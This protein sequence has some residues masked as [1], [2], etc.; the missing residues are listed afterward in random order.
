M[1]KKS[2]GSRLQLV[3]AAILLVLISA[4]APKQVRVYE[5]GQGARSDIIQQ[6]ISMLG[7]PYKNGAKGP[8]AFDCSGFIHYVY[9]QSN[10]ILPVMTEKQI[11]AGLDVSPTNVLPGDLVFFKIKKDLHAGIMLNKK[12]FIHSSKTKGIS[13]DNIDS[14]Y[15]KRSVLCFRDILQI[16]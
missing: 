3:V 2:G 8:D 6:A 4:C 10:I 12:D 11:R 16:N 13:V 15:W 9:K 14:N 7:K 5:T 1:T